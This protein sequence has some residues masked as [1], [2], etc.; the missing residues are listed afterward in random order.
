MMTPL[1]FFS[2]AT[3]DADPVLDRIFTELE[4]EV[5]RLSGASKEDAVG[6]KYQRDNKTG[7]HWPTELINALMSCRVIVPAYSPRYF[8]REY[9][10]RE[11]GVF[12]SRCEQYALQHGSTTT[13]ILPFTLIPFRNPL[14][15]RVEPILFARY[16]YGATY[17]DEGLLQLRKLKRYRDEYWLFIRK[18]AERIVDVAE[19]PPL[20]TLEPVPNITTFTSAFEV[21]ASVGGPTVQGPVK[22][23]P[24]LVNF[25]YVTAHDDAWWWV[26]YP[27]P[28]HN[29]IG[30]LTFDI[31]MGR[32]LQPRQLEYKDLLAYSEKALAQNEII[33]VLV[34]STSL[35]VDSYR[36]LMQDYDRAPSYINCAALVIW[37]SG[38][39]THERAVTD[40]HVRTTFRHKLA[41]TN[42]VYF[43][44]DI[45]TSEQLSRAIEDT[46]IHVQNEV[47]ARAVDEA[48]PSSIPLPMLDST[49]KEPGRG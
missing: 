5:R 26:P 3:D 9:C 46:L 43:R 48:A 4:S 29:Q 25:V 37:P 35:K 28:E 49:A 40:R 20:P 45:Q 23:G 38:V 2:Y 36:T 39:E 15:A 32:A 10:G 1:F 8:L 31:A 18:F 7:D 14:P 11:F 6:F 47:I 12:L 16:E 44:N 41:T 19:S 33:M 30:R 42:V 24:G 13:A 22:T 17:A 34:D 27:P 21:A